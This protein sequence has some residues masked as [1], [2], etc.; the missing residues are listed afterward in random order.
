MFENIPEYDRKRLVAKYDIAQVS[1]GVKDW[2]LARE[3]KV[4]NWSRDGQRDELNAFHAHV[5]RAIREN[6]YVI[7]E[8]DRQF[9]GW[10]IAKR[11]IGLGV[12]HP[13]LE[14]DDIEEIIVRKGFVQTERRGQIQD[15]GYMAS[16]EYFEQLAKRVAELSGKFTVSQTINWWLI[17]GIIA[18]IGLIT[19][20]VVWGRRRRRAT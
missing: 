4:P 12:L 16:D 11:I 3:V 20:G 1:T 13:F 5:L 18:A 19:W 14:E 9:V 7:D 2:L 17:I 6:G 10:E 15:E 8:N